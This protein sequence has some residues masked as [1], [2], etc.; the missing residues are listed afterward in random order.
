MKAKGRTQYC[1]IPQKCGISKAF[2][3]A[4]V[5]LLYIIMFSEKE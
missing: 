4:S 1:P 5:K 2:K 3:R